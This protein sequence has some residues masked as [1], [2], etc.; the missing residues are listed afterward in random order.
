MTNSF[1]E[2]FS[3]PCKVLEGKRDG[4][5]KVEIEANEEERRALAERF[6]LLS[7]PSLRAEIT[8]I[9]TGDGQSVRMEGRLQAEAVQSC[10]VTLAPL[11]ARIDA[12]FERAFSTKVGETWEYTESGS[13][14]GEGGLALTGEDVP[15]EPFEGEN[16]DLGKITSE[17]FGLE[18][19]PFPRSKGISFEGVS[20]EEN[21][22]SAGQKKENPFAVLEKLKNKE[23]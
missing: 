15:I 11:T 1:G 17:Q 20:T 14:E 9:P 22:S 5:F 8:V 3:R 16:I 7:L 4:S 12:S 23:H 2:E 13:G 10:V 18:L 21:L 19:D 6:E